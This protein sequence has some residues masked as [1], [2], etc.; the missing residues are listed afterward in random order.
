[1]QIKNDKV[2]K[3]QE[4]SSFRYQNEQY[5][6]IQDLKDQLQDKNIA[7]TVCATCGECVFNSNHD[8]CDSKF[9]NNVNARIKKSNV[10]PLSSSIPAIK[11][12]QSIVTMHKKTVASEFTI[13]KSKSY[14]RMLYE[15]IIIDGENLDKIKEKEDSCIF[16]G[17][18]TQ[19]KGYR[20]YNNRTRLIVESIH[21]N[22]D[23]IKEMTMTF[24]DNT[25]G[26]APQLQKTFVHNNTEIGTHD[27]INK[28]S[29]LKL[30]PNVVPPIEKTNTSLQELDLLF[31]LT[32]E[33]YSTSVI[34][35]KESFAPITRLEAVW[36]FVA[37]VARKS[38]PIYQMGV[39]TTFLNG[40]LNEE[41]YVSQPDGF[42]DPDHPE[43]VIDFEES[44]A[45]ITRLEAVWIFVAYV[46]RKSFPIYQMGVKMTFLNGSL[47]EEVYV[48]Q[49]DGF[50]DPDHPEKV[51]SLRKALY[52]LKQALRA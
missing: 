43:K 20:V 51:Y 22:F 19:S 33:E 31:S 30:V 24:D 28:P 48:S 5:F 1:D 46:A 23:E 27:H 37:Y 34:D 35:F 12:N 40:S 29:S 11:V 13:Q 8:A 17:Y 15:K 50:V 2:W 6:V 45:P 47:N 14:F 4:S 52:G 10:E 25:F 7:I 38:F 9:I 26:L 49:P 42:V 21:I 36:I 16:V 32:Y 18:S 39:K 41:V 3:Q 44:F